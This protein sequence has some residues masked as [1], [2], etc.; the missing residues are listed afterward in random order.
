MSVRPVKLAVGF[1]RVPEVVTT[2]SEEVVRTDTLTRVD[3]TRAR[4]FYLAFKACRVSVY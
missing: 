2:T 1:Y 4:Y 3:V